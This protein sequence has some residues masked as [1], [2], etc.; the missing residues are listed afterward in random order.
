VEEKQFRIRIETLLE[1]LRDKLVMLSFF[2][3]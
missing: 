3:T 1:E 2:Y